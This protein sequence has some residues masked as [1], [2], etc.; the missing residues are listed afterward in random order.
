MWQQVERAVNGEYLKTAAG[1]LS[2]H[3]EFSGDMRELH[4]RAAWQGDALYYELCPGRVVKVAAGG[5]HFELSPPV[6]FRHF[7]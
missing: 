3:A 7:A 5:S 6:L 2:A 1:T 4:T